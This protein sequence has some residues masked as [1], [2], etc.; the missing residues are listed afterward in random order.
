MGNGCCSGSSRVFAARGK[1]LCCCPHPRNQ[2]S[3]YNDGISVDCEQANELGVN[4]SCNAMQNSPEAAE[5]QNSIFLPIQMSPPL[6]CCPW[7]MPP[8]APSPSPPPLTGCTKWVLAIATNHL[9]SRGLCKLCSQSRS[10]RLRSAVGMC[11]G[12][13][14]ALGNCGDGVGHGSL[15]RL[16][17]SLG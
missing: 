16:I 4:Q 13:G 2:V 8:F 11:A 9:S 14:C 15:R 10:C 1:R 12:R 17:G 5:F 7:R 3:C 6:Q